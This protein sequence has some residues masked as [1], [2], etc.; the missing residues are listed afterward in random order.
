MGLTL[1]S[2]FT[3]TTIIKENWL[4]QLWYDDEAEDKF[5]GLSFYDTKVEGTSVVQ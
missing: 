3:N 2:D 4:F 5:F 1:P